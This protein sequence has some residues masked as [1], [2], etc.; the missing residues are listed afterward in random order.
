MWLYTF[1]SQFV[2]MTK[3]V[4]TQGVIMKG[5]YYIG[6]SVNASNIWDGERVLSLQT[7]LID[8]MIVVKSLTT[9]NHFDVMLNRWNV[10]NIRV[11]LK[12][13]YNVQL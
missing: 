10:L 5:V 9:L 6:R 7:V 2:S 1:E 3:K 12:Y 13:S 4:V 11:V 8:L